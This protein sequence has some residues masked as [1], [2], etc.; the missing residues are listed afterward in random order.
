MDGHLY[1]FT[2]HTTSITAA[3]S[4]MGN[5]ELREGAESRLIYCFCIVLNFCNF[6]CTTFSKIKRIKRLK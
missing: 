5:C 3:E 2:I 4:T 1:M 6:I